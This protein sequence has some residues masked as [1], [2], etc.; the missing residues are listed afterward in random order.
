METVFYKSS[1]WGTAEVP[2]LVAALKYAE[3]HCLPRDRSGFG[4]RVD[5]DFRLNKFTDDEQDELRAAV[6]EDSTRFGV[7]T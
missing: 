7:D 5:L 4:D 2:T 3:A 1:G 6:P